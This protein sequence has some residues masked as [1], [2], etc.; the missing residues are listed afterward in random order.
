[1]G[2]KLTSLKREKMSVPEGKKVGKDGSGVFI[3][4]GER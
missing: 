4:T 2:F 1:M 3:P